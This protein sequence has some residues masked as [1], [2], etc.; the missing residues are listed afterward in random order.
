VAD[1]AALAPPAARVEA[2]PVI[3]QQTLDEL[4][5]LLADAIA[6]R[7]ADLVAARLEHGEERDLTAAEAAAR[8]GVSVQTLRRR[9]RDG[10]IVARTE[11]SQLRFRVEDV[12]AYRHARA[13][14]PAQRRRAAL[15]GI[16]I[17]QGM[18]DFRDRLRSVS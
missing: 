6:P 14:P 12:D 11:G 4:V 3:S 1:V 17:G 8:L 10:Q 15:D 16:H 5:D 13:L 7:V 2:A 9:A 18:G